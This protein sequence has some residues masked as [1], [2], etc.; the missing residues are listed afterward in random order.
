MNK[1]QG[2]HRTEIIPFRLSKTEKQ[3]VLDNMDTQELSTFIRESVI[4][5]ATALKKLTDR[6]NKKPKVAT[7]SSNKL[8][9]FLTT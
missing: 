8:P 9:A 6:M 7:E 1:A 2:E 5:K 3:F 4:E